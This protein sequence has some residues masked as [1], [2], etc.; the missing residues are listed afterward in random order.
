MEQRLGF[1]DFD[2][3]RVAYAEV[4]EGPPLVLPAYWV[5]HVGDDWERPAYRRFVEALARGR[6]VIRYDRPGTGL[7]DRDRPRETLTLDYEV[8]LFAAL[9]DRLEL[10]RIALLAVSSGGPVGAVYASL[11]PERVERVVFCGSYA[12]GRSLGRDEIRDAFVRL[13]RSH[14][15]LGSRMLAD[16][17]EPNA[18]PDERR[19]L[20]E[21]Q[22]TASTPAVAADVLELMYRIDV[23]RELST[24]RMPTLVVHREDDSAIVVRNGR[25]IAALVPGAQLVLLPGSAHLPWHGDSDEL[26]AAVAPFLGIAA[27]E[28]TPRAAGVEELSERER[29]V[30]RLVAEGL[31]DPEIAARLVL[32]PHTVHRH[33]ANIRRKLGL[34]SRSAAAAHAARAGLI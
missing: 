28:R 34:P 21:I 19:E 6:R 5:S 15:G 18:S 9:V 13:V 25:E 11:F 20:A 1:L 26:V 10:D 30:L 23:R 31:S 2:G 8:E 16:V 14:W 29:E 17:F 3:R 7:S 4:G 32:S 27:P 24:L 12:D 22:R 33:V